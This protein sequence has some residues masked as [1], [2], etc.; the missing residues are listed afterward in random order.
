MANGGLEQRV[1]SVEAQMQELRA[2]VLQ[3]AQSQ[4]QI[5]Q[6][7]AQIQQAQAVTQQQLQEASAIAL[8]N[9][10]SITAWEALI[11]QNRVEAEEERSALAVRLTDLEQ[12]SREN[13]QQHFAFMQTHTEFIQRFDANQAEINRILDIL[14][15]ND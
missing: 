3:L 8:S 14:G 15:R 13:I 4:A 6:S 10:K 7:Q 1:A 9:A 12:A 2:I 5:Q 11:E